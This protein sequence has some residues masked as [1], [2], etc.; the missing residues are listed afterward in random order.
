MTASYQSSSQASHIDD[1]GTS[2]FARVLVGIDGSPEALEAARQASVLAE[3]R[4]ELLAAYDIAAGLVG[5]TGPAV[6][7]YYDEE[8]QRSEAERTLAQARGASERLASA[9]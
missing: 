4:V 1:R 9:E 6:P 3:G 2:V 5:G 8:R 7:A